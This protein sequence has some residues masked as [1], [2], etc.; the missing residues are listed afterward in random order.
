MDITAHMHQLGRQAR[1]ASRAMARAD[2]ATRNRALELIATAIERDA[3][4][5]RAANQK[6]LD[7]AQAAGLAPALMDRLAL[8]DGCLLYTSPSPRD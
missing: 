8:S 7:A 2:T 1:I 5:L 4:L 6:D 3:G